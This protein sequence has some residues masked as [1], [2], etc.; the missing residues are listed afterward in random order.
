MNKR[1]PYISSRFF[2]LVFALLFENAQADWHDDEETNSN[3][4][5]QEVH[6]YEMLLEQAKQYNKV[7]LLEMSASYCGYCKQLEEEILKPMLISGDYKDVLIRQ[8]K[9]D[10]YYSINMPG[11]QSITA[12]EFARNKRIIV[13]P[14]LLFLNYRG[15]EVA[16]RIIG[17]NSV[18]YFGA[19]VD[20]ALQRAKQA[21]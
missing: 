10:S 7:I 14:T 21:N 20:D 11:K 8:L 3:V 6:D 2:I 16:K 9:I 17:I 5:I 19:Y 1:L 13:T 12:S 4:A 15:E 18:D